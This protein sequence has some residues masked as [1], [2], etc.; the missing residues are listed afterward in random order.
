MNAMLLEWIGYPPTH[1]QALELMSPEI[2]AWPGFSVSPEYQAKCDSVDIRAFTGKGEELRL[3][4]WEEL[5][6]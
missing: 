2:Q 5:K 3:K 6:K 4:I 1:N